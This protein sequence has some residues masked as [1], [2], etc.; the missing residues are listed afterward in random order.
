MK[1]LFLLAFGLSFLYASVNI[2]T[3]SLEELT[4]LKGVG[5]KKASAIVEYRKQHCFKT[6]EDIVKVKGLGKK[7]LEQNRENLKAQGCK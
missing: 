6:I 7:F 3:A 4:S 2:N 1:I 5:K